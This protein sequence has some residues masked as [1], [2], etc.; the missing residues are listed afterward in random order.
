M[1]G[2]F[3]SL[4]VYPF[5]VYGLRRFFVERLGMESHIGFLVFVLA[6]VVSWLAAQAVG[7][8]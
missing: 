3:V 8:L 2:F 4:I 1:A 5:A 7:R 6:S